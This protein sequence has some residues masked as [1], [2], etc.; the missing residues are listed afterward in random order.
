MTK[1]ELFSK[2]Q[3]GFLGGD[4]QYYNYCV[5]WTAGQKHWMRERR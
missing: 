3:Y 5:Q 2:R 1:N 4:L